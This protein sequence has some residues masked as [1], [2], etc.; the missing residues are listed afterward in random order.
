MLLW[1]PQGHDIL[2]RVKNNTF[3]LSSKSICFLAQ[4]HA[5]ICI[6][7]I[8]F[9]LVCLSRGVQLFSLSRVSRERGLGDGACVRVAT[10]HNT[11]PSLLAPKLLA[12]CS[13]QN[14][15]TRTTAQAVFQA[16]PPLPREGARKKQEI[17]PKEQAK[18]LSRDPLQTLTSPLQGV[19][20][21]QS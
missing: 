19:L 9:C 5:C 7:S 12:R 21:L 3:C 18:G 14:K 4:Q 11:S 13:R 10:V 8:P 20:I 6:H 16:E 17:L 1:G 2:K 15:Q